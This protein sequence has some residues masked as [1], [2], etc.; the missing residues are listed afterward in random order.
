[1]LILNFTLPCLYGVFLT[2]ETYRDTKDCQFFSSSLDKWKWL[3]AAINVRFMD[4]LKAV[5]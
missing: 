4:R 3:L 1:M 5:I 2:W